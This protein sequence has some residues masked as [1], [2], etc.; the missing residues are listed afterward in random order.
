MP[1]GVELIGKQFQEGTLLEV[2]YAYEIQAPEK[3]S[4]LMPEENS[5]LL[6]FSIP[7]LNSLFTLLGKNAYETVL[8]HRKKSS[9]VANDLTPERFRKITADTIEERIGG[10]RSCLR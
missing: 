1:V 8:M 6:N 9:E 10:S 4:P 5:A 7:E 2:A 3:I